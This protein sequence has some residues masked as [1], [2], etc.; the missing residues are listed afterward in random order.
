MHFKILDNN[1]N[2]KSKQLKLIQTKTNLK[3][4]SP[5]IKGEDKG[6]VLI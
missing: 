6:G 3:I 2:A 1:V 5:L 4:S